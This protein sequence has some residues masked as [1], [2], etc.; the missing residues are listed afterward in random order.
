M[1]CRTSLAPVAKK[2]ELLLKRSDAS[3]PFASQY[4]ARGER[5]VVRRVDT[6]LTWLDW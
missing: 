1:P 2:L 5:E 3:S 4:L 6:R